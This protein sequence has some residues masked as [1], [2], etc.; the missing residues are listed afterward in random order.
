VSG[1]TGGARINRT[2]GFG[3]YTVKVARE[4]QAGNYDPAQARTYRV[5]FT[6]PTP[7]A[8]TPAPI[9]QDPVTPLPGPAGPNGDARAP[10]PRAR[11]ASRL[12]LRRR[13]T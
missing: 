9:S 7:P 6:E 8:Q 3:V 2:D 4:D 11:A 12:Q 10:A 5:T 1:T 13:Y